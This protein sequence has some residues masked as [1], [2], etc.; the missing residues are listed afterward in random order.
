[1]KGIVGYVFGAVVLTAIGGVLLALGM[2][3]RNLARA[4][5]QINT[6]NF[7]AAEG[8]FRSA[9]RYFEWASHIPGVGNG[10][11]NDMRA[12]AA[13]LR[14]WQQDYATIVP[15]QSDP[16]TAVANDN[17]G[18]QLVT[19]NA[20]FRAGQARAKD[21]PTTMQALDSGINA[22]LTV[23]K[24]AKRHEEAAYNLEYLVRLRDD[25]EKGRRKPTFPPPPLGPLG[26]LGF[27]T[28]ELTD[29][30]TFKLYVPLD[31]EERNKV[32]NAGKA[33]PK[34]RKG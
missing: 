7:G 16:V 24:N 21:R 5:Q 26:A 8:T 1:M 30:K 20:V 22:Y 4:E 34:P 15:K 29:T 11:V 2:L 25:I 14:Y 12:R 9:E 31:Q 6:L 19:A 28:K 3:D 17:L 33:T 13:A 10:P 32:G 23:L 18:L 27:P